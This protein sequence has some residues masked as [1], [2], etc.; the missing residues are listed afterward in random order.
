MHAA[1]IAFSKAPIADALAVEMALQQ[2]GEQLLVYR[3]LCTGLQGAAFL[4][5]CLAPVFDALDSGG[6]AGEGLM[7]GSNLMGAGS[8]GF[9]LGVLKEGCTG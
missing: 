5:D 6:V 1:M 8:G 4:P 3:S 2:I 9:V 7:Y